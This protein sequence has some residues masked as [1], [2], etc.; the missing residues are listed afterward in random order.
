M[1]RRRNKLI[2]THGPKPGT[3]GLDIVHKN[4]GTLN[5]YAH[6]GQTFVEAPTEGSY[7]LRL[8]NNSSKRKLVV[9]SVDGR[10]VMDGKTASYDGQGYVIGAWQTAEIKGWRR[11][12]DEVAAFEFVDISQSYEVKTGGTGG[13]VGVVG[14]AVFDEKEVFQYWKKTHV[15]DVNAS[16]RSDGLEGMISSNRGAIGSSL[17]IPIAANSAE[18]RQIM[19]GARK[20]SR[21]LVE[22][23]IGT[24]Y[25]EKTAMATT[26]TTFDK[27]SDTPVQVISMRYATQPT[28]K[29]WG[30]I[31]EPV[32]PEVNPFPE[33]KSA[34]PAPPGW[35]G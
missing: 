17:G 7:I 34:V 4:G 5:R 31:T 10:N 26:Q 14:V 30:V 21:G 8:K 23:S 28:L 33:E 2:T 13:N 6:N 32:I 22:K 11:T 18:P 24:G 29:K 20:R 27:L 12:E 25:G 15:N 3:V 19:G 16:Y 1:S 9:I 35:R